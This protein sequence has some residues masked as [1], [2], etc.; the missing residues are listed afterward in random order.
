MAIRWG[1]GEGGTGGKRQP[2]RVCADSERASAVSSIQRSRHGTG[3]SHGRCRFSSQATTMLKDSAHQFSLVC[4]SVTH[5]GF[6]NSH[7]TSRT[8]CAFKHDQKALTLPRALS[9][10][11]T[12]SQDVR[13]LPSTPPAWSVLSSVSAPTTS[14]RANL[15]RIPEFCCGC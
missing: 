11:L 4:T 2:V 13:T 10:R 8:G 12:I 15:M 3:D 9:F 6:E 7:F 5:L 1:E 14:V